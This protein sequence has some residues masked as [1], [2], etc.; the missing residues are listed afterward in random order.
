MKAFLSHKSTNKEFVLAVAKELG[1]Q[2]CVVDAQSFETGK[3]FRR[4]IEEHLDKSSVFALFATREAIDSA[5]INFEVDEAWSR[6]MQGII[7]RTLVYLIDNT[8]EIHELPLWLQKARVKRVTS[9][10]QIAREIRYHVDEYL[11]GIEAKYF[12]GRSKD[13]ENLQNLLMPTDGSSVPHAFVVFGLPGI[14]RKSLIRHVTNDLLD[15]RR[16]VEIKIEESATISDIAIELE[17]KV[18]PFSTIEGFQKAVAEIRNLTRENQTARALYNVRAILKGSELPIF[19]DAGGIIDEYTGHFTTPINSLLRGI[20]PNDEAY[21]AIVTTRKV[22][23]DII[24]WLRVDPLPQSEIK[25]LLSVVA[26]S[27]DLN[28]ST[29]QLCELSDYVRGY[30]PS[31]NY[32]VRMAKEYGIDLVISDKSRLVSFRTSVFVEHIQKIGLSLPQ[33]NILKLLTTYSPLPLRV[34]GDALKTTAEELSDALLWL[35]DRA[36]ITINEDNYYLISDPVSEAINRIIGFSSETEAKGVIES[37]NEILKDVEEPRIPQP[38]VLR[39]L[40]RA[41]AFIGDESYKAQFHFGS[42]IIKLCKEYY[43]RREYPK[44]IEYS[45][46]AVAEL[47]ESQSARSYLIRSLIQDDKWEDA[48]KAIEDA[49]PILPIREIHY[50][51]G[52][53]YRKNGTAAKAII[54]YENSKKHGH[55]GANLHREMAQCYI[56]VNDLNK[57]KHHIEEALK[58]RPDNRFV[59]DLWIVISCRRADEAEARNGLAR[60]QRIESEPFFNH[61]LATVELRFGTPEA[62]YQAAISAITNLPRPTFEM[63]V[64]YVGCAI[65]TH[66]LDEALEHLQILKRSTKRK[67]VILG[68]QCRWLIASG[69]HKEALRV[70]E[71]L[72]DKNKLVSLSLKQDAIE[73]ELAT[74]VLN[75][76]KRQELQKE[77]DALKKRIQAVNGDPVILLIDELTEQ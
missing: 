58:L 13:S 66:R 49:R 42:D 2:Y 47:P 39:V 70:W 71:G 54:E 23:E 10:K 46:I 60:L 20:A 77:L 26:H 55:K 72:K 36:L 40:F 41:Y 59:V 74:S 31:V 11:R 35:M 29:S 38:S 63:R 3:D 57:A 17:S 15:L 33:Q 62:A 6:L 51:R 21:L 4:S 5:W 14:G 61:R 53:Y 75:D 16:T 48:Y 18:T 68:L 73:G 8:I 37:L 7:K 27:M 76:Q 44:A 1:R 67:D 12:I 30:P 64:Q 43:D 28:L 65:K 25:R 45:R 34:I 56:E 69:K 50:L 9:A 22:D 52:F 19:V 32:A 24:P